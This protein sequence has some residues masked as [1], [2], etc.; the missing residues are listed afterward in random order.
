MTFYYS[1]ANTDKYIQYFPITYK[2]D[3]GNLIVFLLNIKFR[4]FCELI[5]VQNSTST[6]NDTN[7][8]QQPV[9]TP[10]RYLSS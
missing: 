8:I 5:Q 7:I 10:K 6:N 4:K 1:L 2:I 3:E 9:F